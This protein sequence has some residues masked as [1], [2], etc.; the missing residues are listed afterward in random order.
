MKQKE[1]EAKIKKDKTRK[2]SLSTSCRS[3]EGVEV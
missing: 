1:K 3:I 2:K